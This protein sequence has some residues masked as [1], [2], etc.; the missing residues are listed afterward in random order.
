MNFSKF[1]ELS[2]ELQSIILKCCE[3]RDLSRLSQTSR[4]IS[5]RTTSD[6][7][8]DL[9][10]FTYISPQHKDNAMR[11]NAFI[12]TILR[13]PTLGNFVSSLTWTIYP[14]QSFHEDRC[15]DHTRM[16]EAWKLL[17]R[18]R[19]LDI[20]SF[21]AD[22]NDFVYFP[23]QPVYE[24]FLRPSAIIPPAVFPE[25]TVIRIGG[26]MPYNYFR[27]CVSTPSVVASLEMENLQGLLQPRDGCLLFAHAV[28]FQNIDRDF[29]IRHTKYEETEDENGIPILRHCG[30]MRGHLQPLLG[31]FVQLKHLK[32][33]TVGRELDQDVRWSEAREEKRY[34]EM[35]NFIK[36]VASTLI[37]FDF[38]QGV[39]LEPL[40]LWQIQA[41]DIRSLMR[42]SGRPM[43][44]YFFD[45]ILPALLG[46]TWPQL[47]RL[48]IRGVGGRIMPETRRMF[49]HVKFTRETPDILEFAMHQLRSAMSNSVEFTLERDTQRVFQMRG[50]I[51][52][53]TK[54]PVGQ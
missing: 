37:T 40:K 23:A 47:R 46:A 29:W 35:A 42:Q 21:S 48:Y 49:R 33:S 25:A 5:H 30:Q 31:K 32:I 54:Y 28:D 16:W 4:N 2:E 10:G 51:T 24:D 17:V 9:R 11:Q 43:D 6:E 26:L 12:D 39:G 34:S 44:D 19:R 41:R 27:A 14:R 7:L 15:M 50:P 36:S 52:Y 3:R 8:I 18:V 1:H 45:F 22:W 53:W 38:E 13:L 20:Y